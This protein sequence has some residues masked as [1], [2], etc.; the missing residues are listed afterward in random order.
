MHRKSR[1]CSAISKGGAIDY[2][3]RKKNKSGAVRSP[4]GFLN[5]S[6]SLAG[7]IYAE[8]STAGCGA[9]Q[10]LCGDGLG[11]RRSVGQGCGRPAAERTRGCTSRESIAN[12]TNAL[13][14]AYVGCDGSPL[15]IKRERSAGETSLYAAA[16]PATVSGESSVKC[17]LGSRVPGRRRKVATREPGDL[18]SA[19]VIRER[20]RSGSIGGGSTNHPHGGCAGHRFAVTCH[21]ACY[22][23]CL[24]VSRYLCR[25]A[26]L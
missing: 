18:P 8:Q 22:P 13:F 26:Q 4:Q 6:D 3:L 1:F 15:G 23:R 10:A 5:L 21:R 20:C 19:V 7:A 14:R 11:G 25:P 24:D 17:P 9:G 12:L 2:L 16:A